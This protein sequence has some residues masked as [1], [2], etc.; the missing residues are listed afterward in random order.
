MADELICDLELSDA[1]RLCRMLPAAVDVTLLKALMG[2]LAPN[3]CIWDGVGC[4]SLSAVIRTQLRAWFERV[5]EQLGLASNVTDPLNFSALLTSIIGEIA[6]GLFEDMEAPDIFG[7]VVF[8]AS[9][10][11]LGPLPFGPTDDSYT[12]SLGPTAVR[13]LVLDE[14]VA[15]RL[16]FTDEDVLRDDNG[17]EVTINYGHLLDAYVRGGDAWVLVADNPTSS[18]LQI[19]MRVLATETE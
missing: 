11:S 10:G 18:V 16:T 7:T 9:N 3:N 1:A 5:Q 8:T 14:R 6:A 17:G 15:I 2:P 12:P 4:G 13:A 19:Q